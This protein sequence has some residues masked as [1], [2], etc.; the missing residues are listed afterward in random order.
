MA[1]MQHESDETTAVDLRVA[2]KVIIR[3]GRDD[4]EA[5]TGAAPPIVIRRD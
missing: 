5:P 3:Y 1:D 2:L 4:G